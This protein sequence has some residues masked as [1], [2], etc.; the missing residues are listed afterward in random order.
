M[1]S[2]IVPKQLAVLFGGHLSRAIILATTRNITNILI[3][4]GGSYQKFT[5]Q[6]SIVYLISCQMAAMIAQ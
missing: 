5:K 2:L 6:N 3:F 4:L 1:F